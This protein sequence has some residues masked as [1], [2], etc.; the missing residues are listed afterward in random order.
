[1][2][3]SDE[4]YFS[5]RRP[6]SCP[7]SWRW[8]VARKHGVIGDAYEFL[9][10]FNS[11]SLVILDWNSL[12]FPR[13]SGDFPALQALHLGTG[14]W[15]FRGSTSR[16]GQFEMGLWLSLGLG[17]A[18][19]SPGKLATRPMKS[20]EIGVCCSLLLAL[21]ANWYISWFVDVVL[22]CLDLELLRSPPTPT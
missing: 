16:L 17:V 19:D 6:L 8:P 3:I 14:H 15:I 11:H 21:E 12:N 7:R 9:L 18:W 4:W 2:W 1:M 20:Y 22:W 5:L 13:P 10:F